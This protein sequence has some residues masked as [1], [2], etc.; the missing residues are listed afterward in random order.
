MCQCK[1]L[2]FDCMSLGVPPSE[3]GFHRREVEKTFGAFALSSSA[4]ISFATDQWQQFFPDVRLFEIV[5]LQPYTCNK[6]SMETFCI[7]TVEAPE[8]ES[9][10]WASVLTGVEVLSLPTA[11]IKKLLICMLL[12]RLL[13]LVF[14]KLN[15]VFHRLCG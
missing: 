15:G 14:D 10:L 4:D 8:K 6:K 3:F 11:S 7:P 12:L 1:S 13:S 2:S 5:K 9:K